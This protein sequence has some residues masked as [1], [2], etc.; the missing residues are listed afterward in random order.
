MKIDSKMSV[1]TFETH[2]RGKR[3]KKKLQDLNLNL[4]RGNI[5][6]RTFAPRW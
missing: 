5:F 4:K 6:R 1:K 2:V 3:L